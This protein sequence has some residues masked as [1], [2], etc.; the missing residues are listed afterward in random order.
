MIGPAGL[1]ENRVEPFRR[2]A[3]GQNARHDVQHRQQAPPAFA[4]RRAAV[5]CHASPHQENPLMDKFVEIEFENKTSLIRLSDIRLLE[6]LEEETSRSASTW[7]A[8]W[9]WRSKPTPA[10][11]IGCASCTAS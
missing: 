8:T 3:A 4:F 1:V 11:R 9:W 2:E 7:A 10:T 5:P 6:L